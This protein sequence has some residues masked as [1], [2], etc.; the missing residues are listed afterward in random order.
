M[1]NFQT[2]EERQNF[3]KLVTTEIRNTVDKIEN[4]F[5]SRK[6]F[7]NVLQFKIVKLSKKFNL[8]GLC[9]YEINRPNKKRKERIDVVWLDDFKII[10]CFEI[11][12][13]LR[14]KSLLK[15]VSVD[16]PF[17]FWIY[18][19]KKFFTDRIKKLI[20]ENQIYVVKIEKN[21]LNY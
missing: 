13:S 17:R 9:E 8:K 5:L 15:L 18:Y 14:C 7:H 19:G 10:A 21:F 2:L 1:F 6:K 11:D 3:V 12:S 20:S 4:M 16:V